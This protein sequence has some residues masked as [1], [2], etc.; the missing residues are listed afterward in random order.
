MEEH[1]GELMTAEKVPPC[2]ATVPYQLRHSP[3]KEL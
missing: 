3:L 1:R 2:P